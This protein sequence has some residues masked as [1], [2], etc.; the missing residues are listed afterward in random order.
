MTKSLEHTWW[1]RGD[2]EMNVLWGIIIFEHGHF[3]RM[4]YCTCK[5][6]YVFNVGSDVVIVFIS[7]LN[8][9]NKIIVT[10]EPNNTK[11]EIPILT[12]C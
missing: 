8:E 12:E 11:Y 7:V 6:L 1:K 10:N 2:N 4:E 3:N 9:V 5:F